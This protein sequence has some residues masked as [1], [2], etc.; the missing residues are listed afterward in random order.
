VAEVKG[1]NRL[2]AA[3]PEVTLLPPRSD[4][5]LP[6]RNERGSDELRIE[7]QAVMTALATLLQVNLDQ[8]GGDYSS[9]IDTMAKELDGVRG[10]PNA[11]P[12]RET[13]W[14]CL[15]NKIFYFDA[16]IQDTLAS[17][18]DTQANAYLLGRGLSEAYWALNP[19]AKDGTSAS[20]SFLLGDD[21]CSELSRGVGR[22]SAYFNSYT[23]PAI[24]GSLTA[25]NTVAGDS[26]WRSK[27]EARQKLYLQ[28]RSWYE[29]LILGQD[30]STL[31]QPYAI[32]KSGRAAVQAVST[33]AVQLI[34]LLLSLG[35]VVGL[36]FLAS[37]GKSS[38]WANTLIGLLSAAGIT[39]AAVQ[40]NLKNTAQS[41]LTRL[42]QDVYSDLVA[43]DITCLPDKPGT[44]SKDMNKVILQLTEKRSLTTVSSA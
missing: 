35:L 18:S 13:Q 21:R 8:H 31:I 44:N 43:G 9:Q 2:D 20:W 11:V 25:W 42:R 37:Y 40:A 4:H 26:D 30:P 16:H 22:L 23:A 28:L 36:A 7:A 10:N 29:L 12:S 24:G 19:A 41:A 32:L 15:S 38:A 14:N 1:R 5:F 39:T 17:K 33:F 6:L 3:H 34:T 27:P